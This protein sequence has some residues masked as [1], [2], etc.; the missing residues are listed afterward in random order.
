MVDCFFDKHTLSISNVKGGGD[1]KYT[2]LN[3]D[4]VQAIS[5]ML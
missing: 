5:G 4:I 1:G 3:P 2:A